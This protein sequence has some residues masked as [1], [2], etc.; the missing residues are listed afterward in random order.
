MPCPF[1]QPSLFVIHTLLV[2]GCPIGWEPLEARALP[3]CRWD[4]STWLM[5]LYAEGAH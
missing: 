4:P 3:C 1:P 5:H 2:S